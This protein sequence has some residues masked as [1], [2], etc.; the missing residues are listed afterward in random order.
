MSDC[1]FGVSPANYPDPDVINHLFFT[2]LSMSVMHLFL[3]LMIQA[4]F[5]VNNFQHE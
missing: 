4:L 5:K 2:L 3:V 1:R